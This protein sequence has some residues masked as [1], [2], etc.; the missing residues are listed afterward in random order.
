[1]HVFSN[2]LAPPLEKGDLKKQIIATEDLLLFSKEKFSYTGCSLDT[3]ED[4][5]YGV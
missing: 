5:I 4:M 3:F 1:M 2:P